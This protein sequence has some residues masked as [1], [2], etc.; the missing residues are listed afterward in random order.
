MSDAHSLL[1]EKLSERHSGDQKQL[2]VVFSSS[3]RLLIEAPAGYGKT[4]TMISRIAY[5]L[6][7][8]QIA[9]PKKLLAL[10]FSVNAAYKIKKDV[11]QQIPELLKD[12]QINFNE[13]ISVSN[14][15]GF[16][17]N[18]LRKHGYIFSEFLSSIDSFET[19]DDSDSK[20]L[21][22]W[23]GKLTIAEATLMSDFNR[24][25]KNVDATFV[26]KNLNQYCEII[27]SKLL[28]SQKIT[29]NGILALAINLLE[30]FS[31]VKGFYNKYFRHVLIDEYQ[32]TNILSY[33]LVTLLFSDENSI[34][35]FGDSLQRIYG[36][37]GAVPN[38]LEHSEKRFK[39]AKITLD[40]NYRFAS[41]P[42]MLKLDRNI[43]KNAENPASPVLSE[44]ANVNFNLYTDQTE[45]SVGILSQARQL[46]EQNSV[47]KIAIL[48][49]QR[50][51][52]IESIINA[53]EGVTPYFYGLFTDEDR[54][55]LRFHK[56]CLEKMWELVEGRRLLTKKLAGNHIVEINKLYSGNTNQTISSLLRLLEIFWGK[57]F[58]EYA[59][60]S[61]EEKISFA[62]ESFEHN[63]LKQYIEFI[64]ANVVFST[65]HAAKGLEWDYVIIPDMEQ[66][67]FPN[68]YGLCGECSSRS[69]CA[70]KITSANEKKFLEELSVFYVAVTRAK[71]QVFFSSS[72]MQLDPKGN[73]RA[74]SISCFLRLPGIAI[75][76]P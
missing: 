10:T 47:A 28:S 75:G 71:N 67:S 27:I 7:T 68:W 65:V 26:K 56:S 58:D 52:N 15:H 45:E 43:R 32:D 21:M 14:Y 20:T 29:F 37:I 66:D 49:K 4:K 33:W 59:F 19:N 57:L 54:D 8:G 53:F 61:N 46:I 72:S 6:A 34:I 16:C 74:K 42:E 69:N 44:N 18:V 13:R 17:R 60:L 9:Y 1:I 76:H 70:L 51:R 39:L 62:K 3:P 25:V 2:D 22:E 48:A 11:I 41:N 31:T 38:L 5:L 63:S 64:Q 23:E 24:A 30:K 40:K 36:F 12:T 35:F 50:G 73:P 55:Y